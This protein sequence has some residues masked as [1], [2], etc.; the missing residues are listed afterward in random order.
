MSLPLLE[1]FK[2]KETWSTIA[3]IVVMLLLLLLI[4]WGAQN[5]KNLSGVIAGM[6]FIIIAWAGLRTDLLRE[7][8]DNNRPYSFSKFQLWLWTLV[9]I[10]AFCLYWGWHVP[11]TEDQPA[12]SINNTSLILLGISG[13]TTLV[14]MGIK[15]SQLSEQVSA[16]GAVRPLKATSTKGSTIINDILKDDSGQVSVVRLQNLVFTLVFIVIY[17]STFIATFNSTGTP[18]IVDVKYPEFDN[19][20]YTLMGISSGSYLLGRGF[21]K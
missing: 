16:S 20:A 17:V 14:S 19:T 7:A 3:V 12:V 8:P 11:G 2:T 13:G 9:I 21:N 18:P 5:P 4:G 15:A 1:T 10:P 6:S